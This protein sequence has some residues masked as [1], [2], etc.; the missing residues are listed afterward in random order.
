[1]QAIFQVPDSLSPGV[2]RE[3]LGLV[4]PGESFVIPDAAS[5]MDENYEY[6][7]DELKAPH[8]ALIPLNDDA[9]ALLQK[10]FGG[11]VP[12]RDSKGELILDEKGNQKMVTDPRKKLLKRFG[13]QYVKQLTAKGEANARKRAAEL[14]ALEKDKRERAGVHQQNQLK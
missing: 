2:Y 8:H 5:P 12:A 9:D 4:R 14:E 13:A 10:T 3:G 1:M 7:E 11:E 6:I